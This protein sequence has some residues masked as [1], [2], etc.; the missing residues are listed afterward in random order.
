MTLVST[1][2][3]FTAKNN[4]LAFCTYLYNSIVDWR[5]LANRREFRRILSNRKCHVLRVKHEFWGWERAGCALIF[6]ATCRLYYIPS[7]DRYSVTATSDCDNPSPEH[8]SKAWAEKNSAQNH[9]SNPALRWVPAPRP[10]ALRVAPAPLHL[11]CH[12]LPAHRSAHATPRF[13]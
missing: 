4:A 11:F 1:A 13:Q 2:P 9:F 6:S 7:H 10:P 8:A 5:R 3:S 12:S